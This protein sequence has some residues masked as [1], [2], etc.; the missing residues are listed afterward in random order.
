MVLSPGFVLFQVAFPCG[1]SLLFFP[2][3]RSSRRRARSCRWPCNSRVSVSAFSIRRS[4]SRAAR[5]RAAAS[6]RLAAQGSREASSCRRR[7][8]C[9]ASS[10]QSSKV[11]CRRNE[12]APADARTR[13]PSCVT[14][15]KLATLAITNPAKLSIRRSSSAA[16]WPTR[17]QALGV[18]AHSAAQPPIGDMLAAKTRHLPRTRNPLDRREKPQSQQDARIHGEAAEQVG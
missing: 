5:S 8:A 3:A 10:R 4:R 9:A 17:G 7:I 15:S 16:P 18:H 14:R 6:R 2:E 13:T 12:A 11:A 1:G